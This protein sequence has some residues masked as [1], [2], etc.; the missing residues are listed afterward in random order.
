MGA[1]LR[2]GLIGAGRWGQRYL[3][4]LPAT[5]GVELAAVCDL[6]PA[7]LTRASTLLPNTA[8]SGS[9]DAFLGA[10]LHAAVIATP[11]PTH[12]EI[13]DLCLEAGLHVLV[14]KPLGIDPAAA[15]ASIALAEQ[16]GLVLAVGH[17]TLFHPG[18]HAVKRALDQGAIGELQSIEVVRTSSGARE[19][20]D[21]ALWAL[22]PHDLAN[23][24][25]LLGSTSVHVESAWAGRDEARA[26]IAFGSVR[27]RLFWSRAAA[28][29]QRTL[30]L[31]G[32]RGRLL[33]DEVNGAFGA[34]SSAGH[35]A[36]PLAPVD[37]LGLQ[38]AAFV[39]ALGGG[40]SRGG[41]ALALR[42]SQTLAQAQALADHLRTT[43]PVNPLGAPSI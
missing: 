3:G 18:L 6:D 28:Q 38:C 9:L 36:S 39:R 16:R 17:L 12:T 4:A 33:F 1:P 21:S 15:T 2:I 35:P 24:F 29:P 40:I 11:T 41:P 19:R 13:A 23:L 34:D 10:R 20:R 42:V 8:L 22:G 25:Y 32:A 43:S 7:A 14:E 31:R 37:L 5:E 27:A 30:E 26:E